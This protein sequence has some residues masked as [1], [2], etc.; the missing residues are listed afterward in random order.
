MCIKYFTVS[1]DL[2]VK[3]TSVTVN[4]RHSQYSLNPAGS[5]CRFGACG[6]TRSK[7]LCED[8][9]LVAAVD[10]VRRLPG[11]VGSVQQ[12]AI[13]GVPKEQ[14]SQAAAPATDGDV[15][16]SVSFLEKQE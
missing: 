2:L 9:L 13:F 15:E 11:L 8:A 3:T 16:S 14:L 1:P 10:V 4:L 7:D 5:A 6:H 12:T